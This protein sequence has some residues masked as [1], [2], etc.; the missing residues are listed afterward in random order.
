MDFSMKFI[1]KDATDLL[2]VYLYEFAD[3]SV[4]FDTKLVEAI[5]ASN[6]EIAV[7]DITVR[8]VCIFKNEDCSY[9]I[10]VN[11]NEHKDIA[12]VALGVNTINIETGDEPN[13]L[14]VIT[15]LMTTWLTSHEVYRV[16]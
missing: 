2:D 12:W 16:K 8:S 11:F 13:V 14:N 15:Q 1:G 6:F 3:M 4:D 9:D 7:N 10:G 5:T